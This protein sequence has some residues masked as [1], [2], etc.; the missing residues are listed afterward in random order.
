M[1]YSWERFVYVLKTFWEIWERK[2]QCKYVEL[3][4]NVFVKFA[5]V[6]IP[7]SP[8]HLVSR[9]SLVN[10]VLRLELD[11][12]WLNKSFVI[13]GKKNLPQLVKAYR[14]KRLNPFE[15]ESSNLSFKS[16]YFHLFNLNLKQP[17]TSF[18]HVWEEEPIY[19]F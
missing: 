11:F 7:L 17:V 8:K 16:V 9:Y 12:I 2:V 6:F 19:L 10:M 15:Y 4:D 13:K 14:N 3:L 5:D 18:L 1:F